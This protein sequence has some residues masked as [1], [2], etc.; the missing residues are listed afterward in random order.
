MRQGRE[1]RGVHAAD[2]IID[3]S[4]GHRH[5]RLQELLRR[6][7]EALLRDDVGDPH[8]EPVRVAGVVLSIDYRHARVHY[9]ILRGHEGD[10]IDRASVAQ[11]LGRVT[12]FLRSRLAETID[13]KRI[14][15]LRFVF[16]AEAAQ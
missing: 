1:P 13:L 7:I 16:D 4:A 6:E 8:L 14:P 2:S 11:A 5:A 10:D 3:E 12:A 15:E 9:T